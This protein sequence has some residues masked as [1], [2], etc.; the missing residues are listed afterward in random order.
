M[1]SKLQ[2]ITDELQK[3]KIQSSLDAN[4]IRELTKDRNTLTVRVRDRDEEIKGKT[5][6]L[7]VSRLSDLGC[8]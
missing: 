6:L 3:L 2:S 1:E 5:K 7:E 4:R 8:G